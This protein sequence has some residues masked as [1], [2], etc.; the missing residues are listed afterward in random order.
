[1]GVETL[2]A[3]M[4]A[5]RL[6]RDRRCVIGTRAAGER[7]DDMRAISHGDL[8]RASV[9]PHRIHWTKKKMISGR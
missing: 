6:A 9:T 4:T 7:K 8:F 3:A 5:A 1:M 2:L